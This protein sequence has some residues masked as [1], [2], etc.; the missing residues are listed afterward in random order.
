MDK[1]KK[2]RSSKFYVVLSLQTQENL[3]L[4]YTK[5]RRNRASQNEW[6]MSFTNENNPLPNPKIQKKIKSITCNKLLTN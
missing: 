1:R 3:C 2:E 5:D 6:K 4:D